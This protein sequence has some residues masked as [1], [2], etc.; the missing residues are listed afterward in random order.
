M[1]SNSL[2]VEDPDFAS[3]SDWVELFNAGSTTVDLSNW[4][5][6]DNASDTTKWQFPESTFIEA[7]AFL[8][9]WC[10][11]ENTSAQA[12][13]S[14]FKL[15][16]S[17]EELALYDSNL[18]VQDFVSF[19]VQS[20][21]ISHGR[22]LDGAP[23]WA[24]FDEPTPGSSNAGSEPYAGVS[25]GV[26]MFSQGGGFFVESF[27]LTLS[28]ISGIIRYTTDGREPTIDDAEYIDPIPIDSTTFLRARVFLDD[29]IPGPTITHSYFFEPSFETR[30]LPVFSLVTDPD[31]FWDADTGIYVQ[32][33][34]P[35]W[36]W[37][38]N[39]EFF[40]NDGNNEAVFNERAGVK[41]NG[42]NSWILPQKMLGIYFRSA[43]G[44]GH[45][46]YP[47][48]DDRDRTRF[49]SFVLRAS[50]SDW[51]YTLMRDGLGQHI[52]QTTVDIDHQGFRPS[53]V[54]IN[55]E[56][57]GIHNIRSRMD[58]GFVEEN[59]GYNSDEYDLITDDGDVEQGSDSA[60]WVM[61]GLFNADL[62]VDENFTALSEVVDMEKFADYWISEI[63]TS[64]SS[65]GH[66]VVLWKPHNTGKWQFGMTDLD[67][68]FSGSTN[69]DIDAFTIPQFNN[70]DYARAWIRHALEN[71]SFA[72]FFA[73]RFADHLHTTFHTTTVHQHIDAFS[74]RI[75]PE[76]PYHVERWT[77]T[78]SSY[79]N[80]IATVEF[81]ENE[82][83]NLR[84]FASE[85][86]PFMIDDLQ[87]EFDLSNPIDLYTGNLPEGAGHIQLNEFQIPGS[88]WNGPYFEDMSL[89]LTAVPL[90][91]QVFVGWSQ[92][93]TQAWISEGSIWKFNDSGNDLGTEWTLPSYDDSSWN[94]GNAE[95]GYGD[96]DESTVVSYGDDPN[97]KHTTTYFRHVFESGLDAPAELTGFFRLRR[98]DG[99]VVHLNGEEIFRSNMPS[100]IISADTWAAD[101]VGGAAETNWVEFD[102][103]ISLNPG[104]N[105][106]AVEIHQISATSSDI[107]FDLTLSGYAALDPI[108]STN[109]PLQIQLNGDAGF[110]AR[111]EPTGECILPLEMEED[112]TLTLDCSPYMAI[113]TSTVHPEVTLLVE[114]GVEI[115]FPAGASLIVRGQLLAEG[116]TQNPI[117][118]A[119][120]P[121][122]TEPWGH[123]KF[124]EST[125]PSNLRHVHIQG[126]SE[127]LHPVHD[128]AALVCWFSDV[129]MD[130]MNLINNFSNPIYA[131]YSDV[132]LTNSTLHSDVT[133]D[134]I[135]VRHGTALIDSCLF[136]GNDQP[137]TDAIDYD[138]VDDGIIRHSII[139]SF[140]GVNSDGIDL[141]EGSQNIWIEGNFIH[142]CTDKGIS[143]GQ[144][145][146]AQIQHNTITQ[147]A[148]GVALKDLGSATIDHGTFYGNQI[149]VSA[150]EKNP[151]MGGGAFELHSSILSNSSESPLFVDSLSSAEVH[152]VLYD[153]D[154]VAFDEAWFDNPRFSDPDG[155]QFDLLQDSPALAAASDGSNLGSQFMWDWSERDV[156]IVEF[157]YIGLSDP[158]NEWI[159]IENPGPYAINLHG[160]S[161][162]DAVIWHQIDP[163]WL[164][165][166]ESLWVV[167]D[168]SF[169][170]DATDVVV[171]W[172]SGQLANEG[173]RILLKNQA[174]MVVDFVK[175]GPDE[176]WPVP[177]FGSESLVRI[178]QNLDN[179]FPSSWMLAEVNAA[180][181][182]AANSKPG[183]K[184]YP[185][186]VRDQLIITGVQ[187][188]AW[189]SMTWCHI[190][191]QLIQESR[192]QPND[193]HI[194]LDI[195]FLQRG[196][197]LLTMEGKSQLVVVE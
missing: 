137:D 166:G 29:H 119:G 62:S 96:G 11:G 36:E 149:D 195:S 90:P 73:Q 113:G 123:L 131:E 180:P 179:H 169:F 124:H 121:E 12:L 99:A 35:E 164:E 24:W 159:R 132:I 181:A 139:H 122:A 190:T 147:C 172:E 71:A 10:D 38:L 88:P 69:D 75:A 142:H 42:Q 106:V 70:Y 49:D 95:L 6:T 194:T 156:A 72:A 178:S 40:E 14:S 60:Y 145:S 5:L 105:F 141:G 165:P 76:I 158:Q 8:I 33:F 100:G 84:N 185:N 109:N 81:W 53:I 66:N 103:P 154:T 118:F 26:P 27:E 102:L 59:Y 174:G 167:N 16:S 61:D 17:G 183:W 128:R 58:E 173:E 192:V 50:G 94:E 87:A 79:G 9:I 135:N 153:T 57:M 4:Y 155:Y 151:G 34:K 13:H 2:A 78:T 150:Y 41:I 148:L 146:S 189:V 168:A 107:S 80:A 89:E 51:A 54:F 143:I 28:A 45:L 92:A 19:G 129:T 163:L 176:P 56:Y 93:A 115:Q 175:Y 197:Y 157:G 187:S 39:V 83:Q 43:Y 86:L 140:Y 91:G 170:A 48:F 20:T 110:V 191:G 161:L 120:Q 46:D 162:E 31:H 77:G 138:V 152:Q 116:T 22:S 44:N 130:H 136:M 126:A 186:P 114:P 104:E 171:T 134:L 184:A 67:R 32:N 144:S 188:S 82:V 97:N 64:N 196:V 177:S 55:G 125:G 63:W 182:L 111:Y 37:P 25:Q 30:P 15:S 52:P 68:G 133:G 160:Y 74:N 117:H 21:D 98:D 1:G 23:S 18:V 47:L 112:L 65:W 101:V 193:G 7:G 127:G 3:T 85:R 108:F